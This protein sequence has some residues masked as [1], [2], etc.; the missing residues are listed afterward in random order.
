MVTVTIHPDM[1][2]VVAEGPDCCVLITDHIDRYD[3]WDLIERTHHGVSCAARLLLSR[4]SSV[5]DCN[6]AA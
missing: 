1:I 4:Y 5:H 6:P 2:T 3:E